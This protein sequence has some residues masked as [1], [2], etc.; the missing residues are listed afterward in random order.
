MA[1]V[2]FIEPDKLL[3][4]T[5]AKACENAH[6]DMHHEPTAQG[7]VTYID[8]NHPSLVVLELQLSN[9]N[10]V[11]FLY[12]L[13]SHSDWQDIPVMLHTVVPDSEL[14]LNKEVKVQL[15]IIGYFYKPQTSLDQLLDEIQ[16][17]LQKK[18]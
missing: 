6:I 1:E 12:E 4:Q 3:A 9:H 16:K 8:S 15:G 18:P 2:L 14:S 17:V 10:G 13:R 5:Y 11:E 7:A